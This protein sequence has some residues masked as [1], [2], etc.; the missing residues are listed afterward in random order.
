MW[1]RWRILPGLISPSYCL[2]LI[3]ME[4]NY[5]RYPMWCITAFAHGQVATWG[6][7]SC[8]FC[9]YSHIRH[10]FFFIQRAACFHTCSKMFFLSAHSFHVPIYASCMGC[11]APCLSTAPFSLVP[12]V[13]DWKLPWCSAHK[14]KSREEQAMRLLCI[15]WTA[16]SPAAAH[17]P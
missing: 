7:R 8:L 17:R 15:Q 5:N 10:S 3:S 14:L 11:M 2:Y 9:I 4:D 6:F 13:T 1:E 16:H 12:E